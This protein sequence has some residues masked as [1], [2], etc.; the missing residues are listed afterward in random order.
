MV[1]LAT[2]PPADREC[3]RPVAAQPP[4]DIDRRD[5]ELVLEM[6]RVVEGLTR[7]SRPRKAGPARRKRIAAQRTLRT[8][9]LSQKQRLAE[10]FGP[11]AASAKGNCST[12]S[13]YHP[14]RDPDVCRNPDRPYEREPRPPQAPQRSVQMLD[15]TT[16][17]TLGPAVKRARILL[18]SAM[19]MI[20][21]AL[22]IIMTAFSVE[23]ARVR[24]HRRRQGYCD[25]RD[26]Y[27][28]APHYQLRSATPTPI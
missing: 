24:R 4:P 2:G 15:Q 6:H 3:D 14:R 16:E 21:T 18:H 9:A 19:A 11:R 20:T 10:A 8:S 26:D 5:V 1:V 7:F 12:R 25:V 27:A 28:D 23:T 22:T 13:R 17:R